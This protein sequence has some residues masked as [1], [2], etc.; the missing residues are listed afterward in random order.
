MKSSAR[1][2]LSNKTVDN[3][4]LKCCFDQHAQLKQLRLVNLTEYDAK[5]HV[6][7]RLLVRLLLNVDLQWTYG[8][9]TINVS[10]D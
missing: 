3:N 5:A 1:H 2:T 10:I 4:Q 8:F 6:I 7:S 9:E